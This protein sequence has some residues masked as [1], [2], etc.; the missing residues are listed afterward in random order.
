MAKSDVHKNATYSVQRRAP[1]KMFPNGKE[2]LPLPSNLGC[3][4]LLR[5]GTSRVG[6]TSLCDS[7]LARF[8]E[9]SSTSRFKVDG[10]SSRLSSSAGVNLSS[11]VEAI[12]FF[13]FS[14]FATGLDPNFL[15]FFAISCSMGDIPLHSLCLESLR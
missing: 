8:D 9:S 5:T 10:S 6:D 14:L 1:P 15:F 12:G 7:L 3:I 11:E 2:V 13:L 4:M